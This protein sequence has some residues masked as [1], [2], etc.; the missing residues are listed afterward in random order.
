MFIDRR[1]IQVLQQVGETGKRTIFICLAG[2][3]GSANGQQDRYS[4][5]HEPKAADER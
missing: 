5:L 2:T 1:N 3:I 4:I